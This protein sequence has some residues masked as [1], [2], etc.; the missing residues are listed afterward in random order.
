MRYRQNTKGDILYG[1]P[2]IFIERYTAQ[3]RVCAPA[4]SPPTM[5][6]TDVGVVEQLNGT[7]GLQAK[8][9]C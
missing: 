3:T 5:R 8:V 1:P 4:V 9:V 6:L 2:V 7:F